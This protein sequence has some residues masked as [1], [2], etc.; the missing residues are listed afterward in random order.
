[1]LRLARPT[2]GDREVA[3]AA[4]VLRSGN[5]VHGEQ[6]RRF[7]A[8]LAEYVGAKECVV[9]SSGTAALHLSMMTLGIGPGD[10]VL[11]P[12]FTFPATANAVALVG[13][14]PVFADVSLDDYCM[15]VAALA[16]TCERWDE[17]AGRLRG[18]LPVHEFGCPAAMES[19]MDVAERHGLVVVEDAACALGARRN[20]RPVG[21]FGATGCFSFHP[22]K[23]LTTGE[24]G[25]IVTDDPGLAERLRTLRNHGMQRRGETLDFVER[26]LNYRMTDFQAAIGL[27]QLETYP[28]RLAARQRLAHLY[29]VA[30]KDLH[31]LR[32][33]RDVEGHIWQT[34]L[35]L[36]S[37]A[38][39]R[40]A[41]MAF[42]GERGV[43][44]SVGAQC[45]QLQSAYRDCRDPSAEQ[46][47]WRSAQ[48]GTR[49][50]ALPFCEAYGQQEVNQVVAVLEEGLATC[51]TSP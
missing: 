48:L 9:V 19:I 10:A 33:P 39:D 2:V 12:D 28:N 40:R 41:L 46:G 47:S 29:R 37:E 11:V 13:A 32:L 3:A 42:M 20:G 7:E 25:A 18:I 45:L 5:L 36:L 38:V 34:Y 26:G 43:E 51:R 15:D 17:A 23:I 31:G 4:E 24:G 6:G 1:V 16:D 21:T 14:T 50:L 30:L 22:R 49:G 44:T 35:V 27:A 8:R